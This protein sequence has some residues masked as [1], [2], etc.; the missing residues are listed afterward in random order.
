MS[1]TGD[2]CRELIRRPSITPDD[3]GCQE[4]LA[5]HLSALGFTIEH[6]EFSGVNNLWATLGSGGPVFCFAGHTDVV[7]PG[8][9]S[10]WR[11]DPFAAE[12]DC[13]LLY[14]RGA[15]DMKGALAAM[16]T[17]CQTWQATGAEF[18]GTLAFL[19]TS[20][21]EGPAT[22]GTVKVMET[23][24]ARDQKIDYCLIGEPSSQHKLGDT[25]RVGRRGSL[26][27]RLTIKGE[28]G[29]VA[30]PDKAS[31]PMHEFSLAMAELATHEWDQGNADF[32]P[33]GFQFVGIRSGI[34]D[35]VIPET[36]N[37]SFNFRYSPASNMASLVAGT[38]EILNRHGL[39]YQLD[40]IHG[41][42]PFHTRPGKLIDCV[43]SAVRETMGIDPKLS[44]SG[45]TSDGRFIAQHDVEVV[46]LG[47]NNETIH[48]IDEHTAIADLDK[49][50]EIYQA[51]LRQ[52]FA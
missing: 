1:A 32:P 15:V 2:L 30:Y 49:L 34:A 17:A 28:Q 11:H 22:D 23:L 48:K 7:P 31:N 51:V 41:G 33:T 13:G 39:N 40:W 35:N 9:P 24:S 47:L 18:G 46:E 29:H 27:G 12:T 21:E 44:T 45:G 38:E 8:D 19:I 36:L 42:P 14:G 10:D 6:L 26:T 25:I 52:M 43:S 5:A 50:S 4:I 20:D 3:Q 37:C 16:I